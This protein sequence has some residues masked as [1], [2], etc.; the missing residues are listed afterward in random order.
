MDPA[1]QASLSKNHRLVYEVVRE[2][3]Y[4]RHLSMSE[5]YELARCRRPG[6]GF[7]TVYRALRRLRDRG[8]VAEIALPGAES[9]YYEPA[10][11]PHSHF[12]C[13]GCGRIQDVSF[14]L[15]GDALSA[16]AAQLHAEVAGATVSLHGRCAACAATPEA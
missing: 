7:T 16:L 15:S 2:Q 13:A 10:G 11:E 5:L 12:R 1:H 3:G 9:A 4:G 14:A 8:L 6:I